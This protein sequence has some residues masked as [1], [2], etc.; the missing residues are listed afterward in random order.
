MLI[1]DFILTQASQNLCFCST[2]IDFGLNIGFKISDID[3]GIFCG[4]RNCSSR[5]VYLFFFII[6]IDRC[7][8]VL[9]YCCY[10]FLYNLLELLFRFLKLLLLSHGCLMSFRLNSFGSRQ[11][12][13]HSAKNAFSFNSCF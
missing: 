13:T 6:F 2:S 5:L 1:I 7:P 8:F 3:L 12:I 9:F 10:I 11:F 4:L